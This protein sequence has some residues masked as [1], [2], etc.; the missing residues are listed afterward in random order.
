MLHSGKP[1]GLFCKPVVLLLL[2][3]SRGF[4][5]AQTTMM[6]R[7]YMTHNTVYLKQAKLQGD[8]SNE[9]YVHGNNPGIV[10]R[11][12]E[13]RQ[14]DVRV[15]VTFQDLRE[16]FFR[17]APQLHHTSK[18]SQRFGHMEEQRTTLDSLIKQEFISVMVQDPQFHREDFW[19]AHCD[20]QIRLHTNSMYF[21]KKVSCVRRRYS[22]FVWL[23]QRLQYNAVLMDLPK[24]PPWNPFFSLRN[25]LQLKERIEGL[26][27]FL[28]IVL[29]TPLL[30]SDS[31]L[32]LFLQSDLSVSKM[33]ACASGRTRYSVAHA[34]QRSFSRRHTSPS[35]DS[36]N[37]STTSSAG[38]DYSTIL[39]PPRQCR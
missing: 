20:Y 23:R 31:C 15:N 9:N 13:I 10:S 38:L 12:L 22:E 29:Q 30:L 4:L 5:I 33:D 14:Q 26:Q 28:D 6:A 34:I 17:R 3:V 39:A 16:L 8:L 32:H 11:E 19:H 2:K 35:D 37:E 1:I 18:V 7:L 21:R 25:P 24:L 36:D 27:K